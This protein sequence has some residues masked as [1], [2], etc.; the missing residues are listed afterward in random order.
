MGTGI[1]GGIHFAAAVGS[2]QN[3]GTFGIFKIE[4]QL[5]HDR[6]FVRVKGRIHNCS[7]YYNSHPVLKVKGTIEPVAEKRLFQGVMP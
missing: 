5:S 3:A 2:G 6:S 4:T 7:V 1:D